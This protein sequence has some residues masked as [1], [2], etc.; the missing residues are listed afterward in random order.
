MPLNSIRDFIFR[1]ALSPESVVQYRNYTFFKDRLFMERK[2]FLSDLDGTLL[3][4][5]KLISPA[6][7]KALEKWTSQG[8]IFA[9]GTGRALTNVLAMRQA[10]GLAGIC[11]YV[12]AYNGAQIYDAEKGEMIFEASIRP[13]VVEKI[14]D[15]AESLDV[16]C[17]TYLGPY[18]VTRRETEA[19]NAYRFHIHMP[20]IV[21]DSVSRELTMDPCLLLAIE[22]EEHSKLEKLQQ[23][24]AE[25]FSDQVMGLFSSP[26]YLDIL[27]AGTNKGNALRILAEALDVPM[28]NTLAAGDEE[29]DISMIEEAG[30]GIAMINGTDRIK[31]LADIVTEEDNTRDGLA[32]VLNRLME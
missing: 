21:T 6:T 15:L 29:N 14:L 19:L 20:L 13:Q 9:I 23:A 24:L 1:I 12:V 22:M 32:E 16:H 8:N 2:I 3:D 11:R 27:P 25:D 31:E 28:E 17:H 5:N 4:E 30:V 7:R 26:Q 18:I 10:L